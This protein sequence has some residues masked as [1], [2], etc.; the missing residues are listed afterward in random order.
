M[1]GKISQ[2][3]ILRIN[4]NEKALAKF[5]KEIKESESEQLQDIILN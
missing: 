1:S 2:P 5:E 4:D 3:Y